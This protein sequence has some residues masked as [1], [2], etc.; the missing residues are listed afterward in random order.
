[1]RQV[2]DEQAGD[3]AAVVAAMEEHKDT[4]PPCVH[5]VRGAVQPQ[6]QRRERD[7][8]CRGGVIDMSH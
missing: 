3:I 7:Q 6:R 8:D 5:D 4:E 1:M 2:V